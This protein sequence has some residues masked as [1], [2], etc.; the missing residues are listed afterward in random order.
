MRETHNNNIYKPGDFW[1]ECDVCG[2][3]Y[4]RS[5]LLVRWDGALV[6]KKDWEP[7]NPLD[8]NSGKRVTYS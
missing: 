6:C 4:L 1:K 3:D 2:F 5:E 7:K 8:I